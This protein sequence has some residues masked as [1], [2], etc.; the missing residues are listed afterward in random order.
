MS[1]TNQSKYVAFRRRLIIGFCLL[2][3]LLI[4][5]MSWKI[6]TSYENDRKTARSQT[7]NFVQAM[8]AHVIGALQFIDLSLASSADAIKGMNVDSVSTPETIRQLLLSAGRIS[9]S[10]FWV[11]FID[12]Q[13]RGVAASNNLPISGVSYADR[14]YFSSHVQNVDNGL[15]IGGPE[16][17]RVSKRRIFFLSRRVTS[18]S[19]KFL[20]VVAAPVDASAFAT[21]FANALF[22]PSL[23]IT[24]A[25]TNGKIVARAPKFDES[26]ATNIVGSMLFKKMTTAPSGTY[27]AK[28]LVDG[29]TRIYSYK[30]IE[31]MP[32]VVSV[33]MA[34]NSW[35]EGLIDDLQVATLGLV[36]VIAVLF[37]SGN[38]A[39]SSYRRMARSEGDQRR[40]NDELQAAKEELAV[41]EKRTRMITDNLPALVA[42]ID[43]NERYVFHNSLYRNIQ[44]IDVS[45]MLGKTMRE[46]YREEDYAL[47]KNE[48]ALAMT[49]KRVAF[50]RSVTKEGV[51]GHYKF[52][53][54]PDFDAA[55]KVAGLY[56]MVTN[57]TG[58]KRVQNQLALL[59]RID[60][61]TGL[62]NRNS[63]YDRLAEAVIR[64][65][66]NGTKLGCLYLDLDHFKQV[67]DTLG[68]AGGDDLLKQF[69]ARLQ[70]CVRQ[71]DM[72]ARL[73][74]DEFVIVI[75]G[76][77]LYEGA[78]LVA[79]KVIEAMQ[80]PFVLAGMHRLITTSIGVAVADGQTDDPDSLLKKADE[81]LYRAKR[82]GK[83][84]FEFYQRPD[85]T[86]SSTTVHLETD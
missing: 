36:V 59:A 62:P 78:R 38:F 47:V 60:T 74:G 77:E 10:N 55:G 75:E 24:L 21:V 45:T 57:V 50:E 2:I 53:Y 42:Y 80:V 15:F 85:A 33:G 41:S 67:N 28:S 30:T 43:S 14:P 6:Y 71:T 63:L 8:S 18:P 26:F 49:G 7:K 46:V 76:L 23:S 39:L 13:G 81:A 66:R 61:L 31:N 48:I 86:P 1:Y 16:I 9:D 83:N 20:G 69:G 54:T 79:A 40:L 17:G 22:Q 72:V 73:A 4:L 34:S 65:R 84:L 32:L 56:S 11:I 68:H 82:S 37:F 5:S 29:D 51:E 64:S 12:A 44:G 3:A 52:E 19:G 58:M 25:H 70:T 27:E 35:T